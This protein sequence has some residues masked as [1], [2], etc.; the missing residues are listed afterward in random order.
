MQIMSYANIVHKSISEQRMNFVNL[1][2]LVLNN[3]LVS[4]TIYIQRQTITN[5]Y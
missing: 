4:N 3:L 1:H 5:V 2:K